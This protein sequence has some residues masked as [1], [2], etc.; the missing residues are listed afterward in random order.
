MSGLPIKQLLEAAREGA[1]NAFCASLHGTRYG[2]AVLTATGRIHRSG[3]YSSFNHITN[4]HAEM[5]ALAVA[6]A[7][8]DPDVVALA[9][10]STKQPHSAARPC[11]VCRQVIAEHARRTGRRI[12]VLMASWDGTAVEQLADHELLPY[13]WTSD[14]RDRQTRCKAPDPSSEGRIRFG[15]QVAVGLDSIGIVW[16]PAWVNGKAWL[17][18]KY[19][20]EHKLPHSYT[21][22][23]LY[24]QA[25]ARLEC[26]LPSSWGDRIPLVS[27]GEVPR[28]PAVP[29]SA[30]GIWRLR[31]L[32]DVLGQAGIDESRMRI[33]GSYATGSAQTDSDVDLII[34]APSDLTVVARRAIAQSILK[35]ER[36]RPPEHS[37]TWRRLNDHGYDCVRLLK[38]GRFAECFEIVSEA[39][40]IR[41]SLIWQ[42]GEPEPLTTG[43]TFPEGRYGQYHG[44]VAV[45]QSYSKPVSWLLEEDGGARHCQT[46]HKDGM[47]LQ[48]GDKISMAGI[49][50]PDSCCCMQ[51]CPERDYLRWI[52]GL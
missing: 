16:H 6:A 38:A 25:L 5:A 31:P 7:H 27:P 43:G 8:G 17:K 22:W 1:R 46:W 10:V 19:K 24:Q 50:M 49:H 9:L 15:D 30:A 20:G 34:E 28:W 37:S 18:I 47:M 14:Q 3:Q 45:V 13:A 52:E 21:Q 41:V 35:G 40:T 44:R 12:T 42:D 36:F 11:G 51:F 33:T 2:A 4:I 32:L 48:P 29:V 23:D 26:G 39:D